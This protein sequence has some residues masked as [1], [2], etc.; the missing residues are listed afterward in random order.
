M[1]IINKY[2]SL[3]L[4]LV[5]I[6]AVCFF[7]SFENKKIKKTKPDTNVEAK[8][9]SPISNKLSPECILTL[10]D[11]VVIQGGE[12]CSWILK[13]NSACGIYVKKSFF[14]KIFTKNTELKVVWVTDKRVL[15]PGLTY[16]IEDQ[17]T[18]VF[19]KTNNGTEVFIVI[20]SGDLQIAKKRH[21]VFYKGDAHLATIKD[22]SNFFKIN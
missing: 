18:I 3:L 9:E 21:K 12:N 17:D 16:S 15:L 14:P 11:Q 13:N 4:F 5:S 8:D 19:A 10:E 2:Y 20:V 7:L 1:K 22:L 6:S